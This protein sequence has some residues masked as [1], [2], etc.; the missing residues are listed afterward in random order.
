MQCH[1]IYGS[2]IVGDLKNLLEVDDLAVI[3]SS[4]HVP[5]CI[6]EFISQSLQ[7]L[8]LESSK[9]NVLVISFSDVSNISNVFSEFI[10]YRI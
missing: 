1:L 6:I 10:G 4:K 5:L 2:D 9:W 7:L 3:L 8:N